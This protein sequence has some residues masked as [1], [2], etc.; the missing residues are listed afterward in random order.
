MSSPDIYRQSK[1]FISPEITETKFDKIKKIIK[2]SKS[3]KN[4][5]NFKNFLHKKT[6][7]KDKKVSTGIFSSRNST[8]NET[9]NCESENDKNI[10]AENSKILINLFNFYKKKLINKIKNIDNNDTV[11]KIA[12]IIKILED[13]YKNCNS[14]NSSNS[15]GY[16]TRGYNRDYP[17]R[18]YNRGYNRKYYG[19]D[20]RS[21]NPFT[22]DSLIYKI[23]NKDESTKHKNWEENSLII[24]Y[25]LKKEYTNPI[26]DINPQLKKKNAN[27]IEIFTKIINDIT[28]PPS[29]I[30]K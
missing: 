14:S 17:T 29:G 16:P 21:S 28:L 18:G 9:K 13:I 22:M 3:Q 11:E 1:E 2:K 12:K 8:A 25:I 20:N 24:K 19:G 10:M 26:G 7:C 23:T 27:F 15:R 4:L 6:K 30:C 5:E